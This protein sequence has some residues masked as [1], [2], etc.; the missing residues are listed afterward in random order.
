MAKLAKSDMKVQV[1]ITMMET[2][3]K[4]LV[5]GHQLEFLELLEKM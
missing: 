1:L 4:V 2:K 3:F 5:A